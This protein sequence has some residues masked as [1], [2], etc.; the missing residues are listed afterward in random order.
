MRWNHPRAASASSLALATSTA[1]AAC[2]L[3]NDYDPLEPART[4]TDASALDQSSP[5][6]APVDGAPPPDQANGDGA[7]D[8]G[9]PQAAPSPGIL[10][11]GGAASSDA[12]DTF[13]L[14]ALDPRTGSEFARARVPMKVHAVEY[15]AARDLWYVLESGGDGVYPLPGDPFFLHVRRLDRVTGAWTE[16]AKVS[17]PAGVAS[18]TTTVLGTTLAYVAYGAGGEGGVSAGGSGPVNGSESTAALTPSIQAAYGFVAVDTS[19]LTALTACVLPLSAA[20]N[21]VIG[22]PSP[23]SPNGGYATLGNYPGNGAMTTV[24]VPAECNS[25]THPPAVENS[26]TLPAGNAAFSEVPSGTTGQVMVASKGFGPGPALLSIYDPT[27]GDLEAQ[28]SFTAG[29]T[30]GNIK[31][32]AYSECLGQAIVTGT[33]TGT[34][35]W[36]VPFGPSTIAADG[37]AAPLTPAP[38]QP[39]GH[40]GQGVYFEPFTNTILLPFSQGSNFEL[41]AFR[42]SGVAFEPITHTALWQPPPDLRP[43]F[44]GIRTPSP[45]PCSQPD[46]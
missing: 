46:E 29:Y 43:D 44:I 10:V 22:T 37:G 23:T 31:A 13:V 32:P 38:P 12:G 21:A 25:L 1:L 15:E 35:I 24:L 2:S 34:K 19:D 33:N 14:T 26:I 30:D 8:G 3:I 16:L 27:S 40:S 7:A 4:G 28:G 11:L 20:P 5:D 36:V 42:L 6:G 18:L 9:G 45:F 17:L 39:F 41:T